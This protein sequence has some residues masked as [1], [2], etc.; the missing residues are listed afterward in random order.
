MLIVPELVTMMFYHD[1]DVII[2]GLMGYLGITLIYRHKIIK[3]YAQRQI[4]GLC[5]LVRPR[6]RDESL[7]ADTHANTHANTHADTMALLASMSHELRTPLN[8]MLGMASLLRDTTLTPEQRS[9]VDAIIGAGRA[10][11]GVVDEQLDLARLQA[12]HISIVASPFDVVALVEGVVEL[13]A[14]RAHAKHIDLASFIDPQVPRWVRGDGARVRQILLNLIGNAINFTDRGGVGVR[15]SHANDGTLRFDIC[16]TGCG[17]SPSLQKRIFQPFQI[18]DHQHADS[19]GLG[20]T[21]VDHI[22][23]AMGGQVWLARTSEHGSV[24]S[25]TLPLPAADCELHDIKP[26]PPHARAILIVGTSEFEM[27]F[28]GERLMRMG[29]AVTCVHDI[30]RAHEYLDSGQKADVMIVD[31][32]LGEQAQELARK[33]RLKGVAQSLIL[34]SPFERHR[35]DQPI[36]HSFDGWLVKP[37]RHDS[38]YARL[39]APAH[40]T[41][42]QQAAKATQ[43]PRVLIAEDDPIN[44][45]LALYHFERFGADVV[46]VSSGHAAVTQATHD[47]DFDLVVMDI[48]MPD[49]D[50]LSA[51]RDIRLYESRH[52]LAPLR[53]VALSANSFA[54]DRQAALD[55][56]IDAFLSKPLDPLEIQGLIARPCMH[57]H[58]DHQQGAA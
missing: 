42:P 34:F 55:A 36:E 22:S 33:A 26:R 6:A 28:L 29:L 31:C 21:I 18:A 53:I 48:R 2:L 25:L 5:D 11:S 51:A 35:L 13:L 57:T 12:G 23:R 9:Y 58:T 27:P 20:L 46:H 4:I 47:H 43:R 38:L 54:E 40:H 17:V 50:G 39:L 52:G 7:L 3:T 10:L 1:V 56:G 45:R 37:I 8:G 19:T 15:V 30:D 24:F 32:A 49:G 41:S 14:A 44:A 16:D